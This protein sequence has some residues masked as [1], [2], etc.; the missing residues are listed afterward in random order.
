MEISLHSYSSWEPYLFLL[1]WKLKWL[2]FTSFFFSFLFRKDVFKSCLCSIFLVAQ[3]QKTNTTLLQTHTHTLSENGKL[4]FGLSPMHMACSRQ[5]VQLFKT[6]K[7]IL[8]HT[9]GNGVCVCACAWNTLY[10]KNEREK[11]IIET[12]R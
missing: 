2:Q 9:N 6:Y 7:A 8:C 1:V 4:F 3:Q 5:S 11:I 10:T 12:Q